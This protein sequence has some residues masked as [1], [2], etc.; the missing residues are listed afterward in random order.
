MYALLP[1]AA[2]SR[3]GGWFR[4]IHCVVKVWT[5]REREET[6]GTGW[7]QRPWGTMMMA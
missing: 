5:R 4:E 1:P 6:E 3:E 2:F 7:Q